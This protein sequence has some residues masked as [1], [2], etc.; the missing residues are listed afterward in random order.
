MDHSAH[1][2]AAG[3]LPAEVDF[4]Y[5]LPQPGDYRVFVQVRRHGRVQT[6]AFDAHVT[7]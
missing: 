7:R 6:G 1:A 2:H 4:P 3:A 5:G